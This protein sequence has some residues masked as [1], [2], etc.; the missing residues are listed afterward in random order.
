MW[1]SV[2]AVLV[3]SIPVV[4]V[5]DNG[6]LI[7]WTKYWAS[8]ALG[9]LCLAALPLAL[10][11]GLFAFRRVLW[12][13]TLALIAWAGCLLQTTLQPGGFVRWISPGAAQAYE[14]DLPNWVKQDREP[15][16]AKSQVPMY[17]A[18]LSRW[19]TLHAMY[20]PGLF[21]LMTFLGTLCFSHR[22]D[23]SRL[24]LIVAIA[25]GVFSFLALADSVRSGRKSSAPFITPQNI[26]S[27]APFGSFVNRNSAGL[28]I[29]LGLACSIG[30]L[31]TATKKQQRLV[32]SD[33]TYE[34]PSANLFEALQF[35]F[36]RFLKDATATTVT[37]VVLIVLQ[38]VA[39]L[40]SQSRGAFVAAIA[41]VVCVI[42][43]TSRKGKYVWAV[44]VLLISIVAVLLFLEQLDLKDSATARI[45][46]IFTLQEGSQVGRLKHW[47]ESLITGFHYLPGGAGLGTYSLAYLPYQANSGAGWFYNADNMYC[48]WFVEGG[49]WLL[50]LIAIGTWLFI[51]ALRRLRRIHRAPHLKGLMATGWYLVAMLAVS[52]FFDFGILYPANFL[53][54]GLLVGAVLAADS[55]DFKRQRE[56]WLNLQ[57]VQDP[58]GDEPN[59]KATRSWPWLVGLSVS[60]LLIAGCTIQ[61][62]Y[63]DAWTD[64]EIRTLTKEASSLPISEHPVVRAVIAREL[65]APNAV[66]PAATANLSKLETFYKPFFDQNPELQIALARAILTRQEQLA[67]SAVAVKLTTAEIKDYRQFVGIE[68]RRSVYYG[69]LRQRGADKVTPQDALLPGQSLEELKLARTLAQRAMVQSPLDVMSRYVL[70][71]TSFVEPER[72]ETSRIWVEQ[73]QRLWPNSPSVLIPV[74]RLAAVSPA[75]EVSLQVVRQA[76]RQQPSVFDQLWPF[77]EQLPSIENQDQAVPDDPRVLILA[78]ES[79]LPSREAKEHFAERLRA[80]FDRGFAELPESQLCLIRGQLEYFSED[81]SAAVVAL[82][83]GVLL[84]PSHQAMRFLYCEVLQK[85]GDFEGALEQARSCAAQ[86]PKNRQYQNKLRELQ[87]QRRSSS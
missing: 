2:L 15:T 75:D 34:L 58:A 61:W 16:S 12:I 20:L 36:Q 10:S 1:A 5:W 40:A 26:P 82:S 44:P 13:P 80:V 18:T 27:S 4:L 57:D 84:E 45:Q 60:Y 52:Q 29:N 81:F 78:I 22:Q 8:V 85:M 21:G 70:L 83:R 63:Q 66:T 87:E 43:A 71:Q 39:I 67:I 69:L 11:R 14:Q 30:L 62:A 19:K 33:D 24:L 28:F 32:R 79:K 77:I 35:G 48:E 68:F 56:G 86:D 9:G 65:S 73:C 64:Y 41:G 49:V 76:L 25:S 50:P 3:A 38:V 42:A 17:P 54:V 72:P 37:L 53:T 31:V 7:P 51:G 46:S 47:K 23:M 74:A 55:R 59:E 6:G